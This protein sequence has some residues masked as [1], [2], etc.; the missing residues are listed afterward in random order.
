MA[1]GTLFQV[2]FMLFGTRLWRYLGTF[3][4]GIRQVIFIVVLLVTLF[5]TS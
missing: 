2:N 1:L 5:G 3:I 4:S